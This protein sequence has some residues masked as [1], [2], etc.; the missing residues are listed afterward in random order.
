MGGC[1][2]L[3]RLWLYVCNEATLNIGE[4][5]NKGVPEGGFMQDQSSERLNLHTPVVRRAVTH[6]VPVAVRHYM[7]GRNLYHR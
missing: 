4:H 3:V 1:D 7:T 6:V 5:G 2:G